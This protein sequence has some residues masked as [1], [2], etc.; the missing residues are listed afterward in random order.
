MYIAI[1]NNTFASQAGLDPEKDGLFAEDK[2]S[3]YVNLIV[4]RTDNKDDE[5]IRKFVQAYQSPEVEEVARKIF[6]GNAVKG[7]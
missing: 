1:I 5:R 4:T 2:E 7:W 3:P 6:K